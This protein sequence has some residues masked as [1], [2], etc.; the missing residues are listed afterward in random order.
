MPEAG[1]VCTR[2]YLTP[3]SLWPRVNT[4]CL[5]LGQFPED[6]ITT[7]GFLLININ[8]SILF[9]VKQGDCGLTDFPD[10]FKA[11]VGDLKLDGNCDFGGGEL[12]SSSFVQ[13]LDCN[14]SVSVRG[15]KAMSDTCCWE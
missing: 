7:R 1:P 14:E 8:F 12:L 5:S 11:E 4:L 13:S 6:D 15:L 9:S 10:D 2:H 3:D